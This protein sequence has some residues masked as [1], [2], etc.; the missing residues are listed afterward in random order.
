MDNM[1][2]GNFLIIKP[3]IFDN[4]VVGKI[5]PTCKEKTIGNT[6]HIKFCSKCGNTLNDLTE[7]RTKSFYSI[8]DFSL[9]EQALVNNI[10]AYDY[11]GSDEV[12]V[13]DNFSKRN[14]ILMSNDDSLICKIPKTFVMS[15]QFK[16]FMQL[17][18]KRS[19]KYKVY[20]NSIVSFYHD[21]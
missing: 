17:I 9:E 6:S 18:D 19:L 14:G 11:R 15:K 4:Y 12:I 20:E 21:C 5:C 8:E 2:I 10:T 16:E 3:I 13:L 1:F 7:K